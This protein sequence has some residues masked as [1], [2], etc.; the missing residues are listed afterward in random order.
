MHRRNIRPDSAFQHTAARR[1]LVLSTIYQHLFNRVSTHSRPKA[2]GSFTLPAW[3]DVIVST[4]SRPKAAGQQNKDKA[5]TDKFQHTAARRRLAL[6]SYEGLSLATVSTHSRPKAAGCQNIKRDNI[7]KSFNT[8]PP[9]GGWKT[10]ASMSHIKW[11]FQHTAARR[12]LGL[13][14]SINS[15]LGEV[16]THSRPKA[17]GRQIEDNKLDDP[18]STHSRPK[19]AGAYPDISLAAARVS[20]HS[21]PKAAGIRRIFKNKL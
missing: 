15:A 12:R 6:V 8:Q 16:S 18:V 20:T 21:R 5:T 19:A 17:A 7:K 2:A 9:E 13:S 4:H 1:R 14:S 11:L 3:S 10:F